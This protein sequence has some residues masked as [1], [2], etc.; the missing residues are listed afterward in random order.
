MKIHL[1]EPQLKDNNG[2]FW[3]F[4]A[5]LMDCKGAKGI[6]GPRPLPRI[7]KPR[8]HQSSWAKF[9][10]HLVFFDMSDHTNQYD[11]NALELCDVYFKANL[12]WEVTSRVLERSGM[13]SHRV[14]IVPFFSLA[15]TIELFRLYKRI[16]KLALIGL[17]KRYDVCQIN[18][19]DKPPP[20]GRTIYFLR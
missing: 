3:F 16:Y 15:P 6:L 8:G 17:R 5:A 10:N 2:F 4:Y 11:L 20:T 7:T 1:Y 19:V 9:D 14:K 18:G 13:L 12:N